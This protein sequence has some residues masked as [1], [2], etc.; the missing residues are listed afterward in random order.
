MR[1]LAHQKPPPPAI[2][3]GA[4]SGGVARLV[5]GARA[6]AA[7]VRDVFVPSP[8]AIVFGGGRMGLRP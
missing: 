6:A 4:S 8:T 2:G 3:I 1:Q 7:F 5:W